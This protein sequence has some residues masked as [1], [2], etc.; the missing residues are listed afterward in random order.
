MVLALVAS[1][2]V[3]IPR[4]YIARPRHEIRLIVQGCYEKAKSLLYR[5]FTECST[6]RCECRPLLFLMPSLC[7][8]QFG[9]GG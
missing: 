5:D 3:Q 4:T 7:N 9:H 1:T 2:L 6:A 8:V